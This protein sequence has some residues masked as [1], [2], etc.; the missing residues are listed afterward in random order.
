MIY[1]IQNLYINFKYRIYIIY[2]LQKHQK[3]EFCSYLTKAEQRTEDSY[4][5]ALYVSSLFLEQTVLLQWC[6]LQL[7]NILLQQQIHTSRPIY[8]SA[9]TLPSIARSKKRI[10]QQ[11]GFFSQYTIIEISGLAHLFSV[12]FGLSARHNLSPL[13]SACISFTLYVRYIFPS[14]STV[15]PQ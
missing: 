11:P 10:S 15:W 14:T 6:I 5:Q 1:I 2:I 9:Q 3:F 8:T 4:N 7:Y 13:K 12:K